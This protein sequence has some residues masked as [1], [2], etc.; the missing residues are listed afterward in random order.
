MYLNKQDKCAFLGLHV[1]TLIP[2]VS[3]DCL[4]LGEK[5]SHYFLTE[6]CLMIKNGITAHTVSVY[7]QEKPGQSSS[8]TCYFCANPKT[9]TVRAA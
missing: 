1:I 7:S 5:K 2:N 8:C 9:S 3:Q 4:S 6:V